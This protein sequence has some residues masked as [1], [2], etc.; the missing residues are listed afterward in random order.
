MRDQDRV[1]AR[2]EQLARRSQARSSEG[3]GIGLAM[4]KE[5]TELLGGQVN[6]RSAPGRGSTFTVRLPFLP[7]QYGQ[8]SEGA[9]SIT[10]RGV[11]AFLAEVEGW[12]EPIAPALPP[13]S[14]GPRPRLLIAEDSVDM[15]RYLAEVL[16]DSYE[17][18]SV[19][20]GL[21]ALAAASLRGEAR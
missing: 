16:S 10:P 5:L 13:Q 2:F 12:T 8:A 6:L 3:A 9:R 21:Q 14:S 20:D 11:H 1:F 4:V 18:E 17:V 7:P 19:S 15:A